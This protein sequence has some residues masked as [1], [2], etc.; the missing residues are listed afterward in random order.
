MESGA[1]IGEIHVRQEFKTNMIGH[2]LARLC[3]IFIMYEI[4]GSD[5]W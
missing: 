2:S 5:N 1:V 4:L 3:V